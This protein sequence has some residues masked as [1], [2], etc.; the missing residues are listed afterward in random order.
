MVFSA[1]K[2]GN[3]IVQETLSPLPAD[4]L[5]RLK[6]VYLADISAMPTVITRLFALPK[7]RELPFPIGLGREAAQLA[8]LPRQAGMAT[9]LRLQDNKLAN[10]KYAKDASELRQAIGLE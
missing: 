1:D 3:G 5:S 4:T 2:A 6:A 8:D 10:V 7:L 9:V